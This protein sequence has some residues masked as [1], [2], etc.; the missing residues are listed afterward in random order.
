MSLRRGI[1]R[2]LAAAAVFAAAAAGPA[3][4]EEP[5]TLP[6]VGAQL[7]YRAT[8]TVKVAGKPPTVSG[9]VYAYTVTAADSP[10]LQA[11]IRPVGVIIDC[12]ADSTSKDCAFA[13]KAEGATREGNLVTVPVPAAIADTLA[14][15]GSLTTRYFVTENRVFP[16]PGPANPDDPSDGAF[17]TTP[18]F[19]LT[20]K[21][22]CDQDRLNEFF[23]LGRTDRVELTCHNTFSRTEARA[24]PT[25]DANSDEAAQAVLTYGGTGQTV[26]PSGTWDIRKVT[27][28]LVPPADDTRHPT[29]QTEFEIADKLGVPVRSQ[30]SIEIKAGNASV[31]TLSELIDYKP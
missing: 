13:A 27:L 20:T 11:T 23:P 14:K 10:L 4:A 9:M 5:Y 31:A 3:A 22:L 21:L 26:L 29:A 19:M 18:L 15:R 7:T 28:R 16:M 30:G 12:P 25:A 24:G 8:V 17:G 6:P 2:R 1:A